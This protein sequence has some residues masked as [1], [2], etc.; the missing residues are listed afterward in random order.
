MHTHR[1]RIS[2]LAWARPGELGVEKWSGNSG[3]FIIDRPTLIMQR[4]KIKLNGN[5]KRREISI[6]RVEILYSVVRY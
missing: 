3:D 2:E 4:E 6:H 1:L 5:K